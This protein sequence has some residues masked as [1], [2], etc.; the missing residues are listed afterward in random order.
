MVQA[1]SIF[2]GPELGDQIERWS[3]KEKEV[4]SVS[5]P[6]MIHMKHMGGVDLC[7][8]LMSLCSIELGSR[9]WYTHIVYYCIGVA[10][11]SS[12]VLMALHTAFKVV[13]IA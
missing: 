10:V 2:V 12:W 7:K 11:T 3:S 5:C 8:M 6:Q 9:K 4:V 1:L 13:D